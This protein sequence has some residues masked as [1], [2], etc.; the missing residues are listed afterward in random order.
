MTEEKRRI[1]EPGRAARMQEQLMRDGAL[2][3]QRMTETLAEL[4]DDRPERRHRRLLHPTWLE[5]RSREES[6]ALED[7]GPAARPARGT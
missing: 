5:E 3:M 2:K 6:P 1:A 4:A 7:I